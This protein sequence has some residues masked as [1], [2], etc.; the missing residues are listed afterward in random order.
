[1]KLFADSI[2]TVRANGGPT[3]SHLERTANRGGWR[4]HC[5][6]TLLSNTSVP[7]AL[8]P[9]PTFVR[10]ALLPRLVLRT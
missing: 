10:S 7:F 6:F 1:M 2:V 3:T 5:N 4:L 8:T 9:R